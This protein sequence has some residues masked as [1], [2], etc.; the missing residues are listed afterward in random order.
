MLSQVWRIESYCRSCFGVFVVSSESKKATI[1]ADNPKPNDSFEIVF[2]E[3]SVEITFT[4]FTS[5][6][7]TVL[8]VMSLVPVPQKIFI[9]HWMRK[10]K[11]VPRDNKMF[12]NWRFSK[13]NE[14]KTKK[15]EMQMSQIKWNANKLNIEICQREHRIGHH[16][17]GLLN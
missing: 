12:V 11:L 15:L 8:T 7:N 6:F 17:L 10:K 3:I 4:N 1:D 16:G 9:S 13:R 2:M 5:R 14:L